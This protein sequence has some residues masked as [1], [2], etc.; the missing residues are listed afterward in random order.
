MITITLINFW[1]FSDWKSLWGIWDERGLKLESS[2][3]EITQGRVAR[4]R[5]IFDTRFRLIGNYQRHFEN[6]RKSRLLA[7]NQTLFSNNFWLF[8]YL[9][10]N[11]QIFAIF[12]SSGCG[13]CWNFR[14]QKS[15]KIS[16]LYYTFRILNMRG[17]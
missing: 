13:L 11:E 3:T 8:Y 17:L 1:L 14:N 16:H 9:L 6:R 12:N 2:A 4:F 15:Y 7:G 5:K 10:F